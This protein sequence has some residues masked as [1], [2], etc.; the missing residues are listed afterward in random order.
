MHLEDAVTA[1]LRVRDKDKTYPPQE[2]EASREA[3]AA[4]L[5]E[6]E[7]LIRFSALVDGQF[8]GHVSI[9]K[10]HDYLEN[11]LSLQGYVTKSENG[12]AEI[13]KFFVDP[14]HR[15]HGL[16]HALFEQI[17]HDAF[18]AGYQP[19]LAVVD[20]SED[21]IRFYRKAGMHEL[22]YF[23]GFHGKNLIFAYDMPEQKYLVPRSL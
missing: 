16:G 4:W 9:V 1:L 23:N 3:F 17:R 6:E 22:G 11:H 5:L 12:F 19:A 18:S 8:A 15:K 13:G 21:A 20:T 7:T 14:L 2:N 10:A